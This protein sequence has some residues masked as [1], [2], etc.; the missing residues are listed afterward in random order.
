M[1]LIL[2]QTVKVRPRGTSITYYTS[3]GY[4]YKGREKIDVNVVDLLPSSSV[5]V[6]V[7][8]D[9]CGK[10]YES[11]Y[12][13]VSKRLDDICCSNCK[14]NKI[15]RTNMKRYGVTS[16]SQ[17]PEVKQRQMHTLIKNYGV[18]NPMKSD[19]LKNRF[20]NTMLERYGVRYSSESEL[21][22][23]KQQNTCELKYG[24]KSVLILEE[25]Q[26]K[27]Q[28]TL[29]ENYGVTNPMYSE[30]IKNKLYETNIKRY[31]FRIPTQND[32]IKHKV[33]KALY[34]NG[35][36]KC[37]S[38]QKYLYDLF[39]GELNYPIGRYNV[40]IYFPKFN[41][42][43]EYDGG[44]HSFDVKMGRQTKED[45]IMKQI[46]RYNILKRKGL[47]S[48]RF[49]SKTDKLPSDEIL[50]FLKEYSIFFLENFDD[51]WIEINLDTYEIITIDNKV[52]FNV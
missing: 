22:K 47:K 2:P 48:I 51:N 3:L 41:I 45:F 5:V 37:S 1:G 28:N 30:I 38:Q 7:K 20:E 26:T 39:G 46:I 6:L 42:Y 29:M 21:L 25:F 27:R 34:N 14:G 13:E 15:T 40:D 50:L 43:F 18:D 16:T 19:L 35:T 8:C 36:C 11:K 33:C 44:M 32:E 24:V 49:T 31:G 17:I 12:T 10:E 23:E 9:Y 4:E 52:T